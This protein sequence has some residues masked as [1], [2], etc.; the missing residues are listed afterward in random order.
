MMHCA[1]MVKG[2]LYAYLGHFSQR[3]YLCQGH[4]D[5]DATGKVNDADNQ[6]SYVGATEAG[7]APGASGGA[8]GQ[9]ASVSGA[10]NP[11]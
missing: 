5:I 6:N 3:Q 4:N 7:V 9:F 10:G 8:V 2:P 11:L 1:D